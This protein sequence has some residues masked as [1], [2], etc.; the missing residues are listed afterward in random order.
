MTKENYEK[1]S[2][3]YVIFTLVV[4]VNKEAIIIKL[5]VSNN[6]EQLICLTK[7]KKKKKR[8]ANMNR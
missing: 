8:P 2:V 4:K 5:S 3:R 6:K 7:K 1:T